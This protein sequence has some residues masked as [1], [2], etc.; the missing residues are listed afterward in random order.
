[1]RRTNL[2][3]VFLRVVVATTDKRTLLVAT[4][5]SPAAVAAVDAAVDLALAMNGRIRFVHADAALADRLF[6][7]YREDGAPRQQVLAR[8]GVLAEAI[9]RAEAREESRPTM[10][11]ARP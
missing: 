3:S 11:S 10:G 8:D 4:D 2:R 1:M 7:D 6:T 5:G 9:R